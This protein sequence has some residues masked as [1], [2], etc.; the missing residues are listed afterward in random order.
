MTEQLRIAFAGTPAFALPCLDAL[1]DSPHQLVAVFTQPDKPA[2]RGRVLTASPVK[3]WALEHDVPVFQPET[4]KDDAEQAMMAAL[5]LDVLIVVAYG[6]LLPPAILTTPGYGCLNVHASLLPRWRGAAP[7]Q[8]A[9]LAG[10]TQT[11]ITIMQMDSGLDTGPMLNHIACPIEPTDTSQTL[12]DRLSI[13][14]AEAL[15]IA[16]SHL[17]ALRQK[18]VA[19]VEEGATYAPKIKKQQALI[20]WTQ[21]A[22]QLERAVRAF[23]PWP[24]AFSFLQQERVRVWGACVIDE[25]CSAL[26]GT[27]VQVGSDGIDV[28]TG[29]KVLRLLRVQLAGGSVVHAADVLNAKADLFAITNTFSNK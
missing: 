13:L 3:L 22:I 1:I 5:N 11:G 4:L 2:G 18:A 28:A 16:L 26:P 21:P 7:I 17:H 14:G 8:H 29:E 20:D 23:I 10:D 27:I 25:S 6:L 15:L 24:V 9:I 12:H 19:Q